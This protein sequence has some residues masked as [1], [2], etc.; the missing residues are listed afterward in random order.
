MFRD[1][2]VSTRSHRRFDG[3]TAID[4]GTLEELVDLARLSASGGNLQP[5]K[6]ILSCDSARNAAIF[7]HLAWAAYLKDWDGPAE[8]ER[9]AAYIVILC[10]KRISAAPGCDHGIAA[11]TILLGA[12]AKGLRGCLL[13][14]IKREALRSALAIPE[15]FD[16]LLVAALG[17]AAE[18]VRIDKIP[19]DGS[20]KYWRDAAGVHHVPKRS[21]GEII[22][23]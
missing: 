18:E 10:D 5:L 8:G 22:V 11:Q 7:P 21:L 23:G 6:Y 9:P 2:V 12:T 19:A 1:L 4:R 13:G 20:I 3:R 14:S 16:I 15:H 17:K